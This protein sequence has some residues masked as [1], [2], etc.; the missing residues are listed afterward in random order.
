[1][2]LDNGEEFCKD[3]ISPGRHLFSF[4]SVRGGDNSLCDRVEGISVGFDDH[5]DHSGDFPVLGIRVVIPELDTKL[6]EDS[7]GLLACFSTL[8]DNRHATELTNVACSLAC[9]PSFLADIDLLKSSAL[10]FQKHHK[11]SWTSVSTWEVLDLDD[12]STSRSCESA[13]ITLRTEIVTTT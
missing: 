13:S 5:V 3:T 7:I 1:M 11:R 6:T 4:L 10:V 12:L 2:F 9:A 8:M